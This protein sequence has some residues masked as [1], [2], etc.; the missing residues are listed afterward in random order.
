MRLTPRCNLAR[1]RAPE[2][3]ELARRVVDVAAD[4]FDGG[5]RRIVGHRSEHERSGWLTFDD[6]RKRDGAATTSQ[7]FERERS[8]P[9][10]RGLR[11]LVDRRSGNDARLT[12]GARDRVVALVHGDQELPGGDPERVIELTRDIRIAHEL[13]AEDSR[14]GVDTHDERGREPGT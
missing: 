5:E 7:A 4:H 8:I 11:D 1:L 13:T 14:T 6:D 9:V 2:L 10:Q 3:R 12:H